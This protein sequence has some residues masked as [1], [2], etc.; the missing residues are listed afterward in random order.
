M[1]LDNYNTKKNKAIDAFESIGLGMIENHNLALSDTLADIS[2]HLSKVYLSQGLHNLTVNIPCGI[3]DE[4]ILP[5]ELAKRTALHALVSTISHVVEFDIVSA[6][7]VCADLMEDVNGH[8]EAKMLRD[9][10][11]NMSNEA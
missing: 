6:L 4:N 1:N 11:D 5:T 8:A 7:E 10:A 9:M 2:G 3:I